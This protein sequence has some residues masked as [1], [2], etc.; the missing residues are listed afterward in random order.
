MLYVIEQRLKA[1]NIAPEKS[2]QGKP[3]IDYFINK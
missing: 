2:V 3:S 1:Q